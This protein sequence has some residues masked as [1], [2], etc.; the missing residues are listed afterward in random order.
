MSFFLSNFAAQNCFVMKKILVFF[1]CVL[2]A[3]S[4]CKV[5]KQ[6]PIQEIQFGGGG[7]ATSMY[8]KHIVNSNG[9]VFKNGNK[10][11]KLT[12]QELSEIFDLAEQIDSPS[13][14]PGNASIYIAIVRKDT[15]ISLIW[16][17]HQHPDSLTNELYIKL[18]SIL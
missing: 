7:G 14:N 17:W 8:S 2:A 15:T 18:N 6:S 5:A 13:V 12:C 3:C 10:L 9:E 16:D 11:K 4:T 1:V